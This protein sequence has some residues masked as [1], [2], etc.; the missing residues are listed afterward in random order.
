MQNN[1]VWVSKSRIYNYSIYNKKKVGFER[2]E[3]VSTQ[4]VNSNSIV[5]FFSSSKNFIFPVQVGVRQK[6]SSSNEFE[7]AALV[8]IVTTVHKPGV[9]NFSSRQATCGIMKSLTLAG[10]II[11]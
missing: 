7:F 8:I 10:Q 3:S 5:F 9:G 11:K 2:F 4:L 6:R 1:A